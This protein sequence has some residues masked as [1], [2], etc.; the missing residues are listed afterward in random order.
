MTRAVADRDRTASFD[1]AAVPNFDAMPVYG[2][3][4]RTNCASEVISS[5]IMMR[6]R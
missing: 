3:R 4:M 2:S 6:L 1:S 5:F